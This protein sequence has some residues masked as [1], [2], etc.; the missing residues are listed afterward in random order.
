MEGICY[1]IQYQPGSQGALVVLPG[2]TLIPDL[3]NIS[4]HDSSNVHWP[5]GTVCHERRFGIQNRDAAIAGSGR[6]VSI[7]SYF[8]YTIA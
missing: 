2:S 7:S 3:A 1:S 6:Q 4:S 5:C 8:Q